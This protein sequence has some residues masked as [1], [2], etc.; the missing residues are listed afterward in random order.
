MGKGKFQ[1]KY[2]ISSI[3]AQ[4]WDYGWNGAYFITICTQDRKHYFGEIQNNKMILSGVGIIADLLWHQIPIHHKN[5]ELGDFVVM[6]NH[7]HGI[8]IIDKQLDNVNVD[9][10]NNVRQGMPCLY[11]RSS[12]SINQVHNVFKTLEKIPFRQLLDHINLP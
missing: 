6:P 2:R 5:V 8:L 12:N 10:T 3:R 1:N 11:H 4:W 7:I 9:N